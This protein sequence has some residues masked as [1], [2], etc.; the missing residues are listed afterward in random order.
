MVLSTELISTPVFVVAIG[1]LF[2]VILVARRFRQTG[3]DESRTAFAGALYKAGF[4]YMLGIGIIWF[5]VSGGVDPELWEIVFPL[6]TTGFG[7]LVALITLPLWIGE[8]IVMRLRDTDSATAW[9]FTM[10]GWPVA[11][12]FVLAIFIAINGLFGE[13]LLLLER[14]WACLVGFCGVSLTFGGVMLLM[15]VVAVGAPG[16]VGALLLSRR[17]EE[18]HPAPER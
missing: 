10:Y 9:R 15:I 17:S 12:P 11:M 6:L 1:I 16:L 13:D 8:Q 5:I 3:T 4:L 7:A 18:R 14:L 2:S